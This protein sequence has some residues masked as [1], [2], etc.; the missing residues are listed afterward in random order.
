MIIWLQFVACTALIV[1]C[2]WKL[3][4]Y[5]DIIAEKTGLGRTWIGVVLMASVTSLPELITG[6]S[7]VAIF[8][9]PNIAAGD[10]LGSCMVNML[11][12]AV[13]DFMDGPTPLSARAHQGQVLGAGFGILL[14]GLVSISLLG[15]ATMPRIGWVSLSSL[16]FLGIYL[17]AIRTV[18]LYE[19]RR[20]G[21]FAQDVAEEASYRHITKA[22]AFTMYGLNAL[23]IIVAATYLPHLGERI[24]DVTGLGRTF[25]G[26]VFIAFSTSLP[27]LVVS[28]GALRLG[29]VDIALGNLFGSNLFNIGILALD[30]VLY[31][32]GALLSNV[33]QGHLITTSA[34]IVMTAIAVIGLTYQTTRKLR[35]F[36]WDSIAIIVVYAAATLLL[37]ATGTGLE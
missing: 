5:G 22:R 20:I 7:S 23:V 11:I 8:D 33:S 37:Y 34:A 9:L 13:L 2:G 32:K 3:A 4:L 30:D 25:V 26:S 1:F 24:A 15:S 16:V 18:F 21:E 14:L 19:R 29:A 28:L 10:A 17:V 31:T 36:A 12:I 35:F 6:F 27:E